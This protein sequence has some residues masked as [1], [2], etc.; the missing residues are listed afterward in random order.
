LKSNE[1]ARSATQKK[2]RALKD[3]DATQNF[4]KNKISFSSKVFDPTQ[5]FDSKIV[6]RIKIRLAQKRDDLVGLK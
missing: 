1:R 2:E 6:T 5:N 3:F 4:H